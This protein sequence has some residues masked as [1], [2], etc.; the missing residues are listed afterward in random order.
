MQNTLKKNKKMLKS[1]NVSKKEFDKDFIQK[2]YDA[3]EFKANNEM[4]KELEE[5]LRSVWDDNEFVTGVISCVCAV[6]Q[7]EM[8]K[9]LI[10]SKGKKTH[11]KVTLVK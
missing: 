8:I 1:F 2:V 10:V 9:D 5:L 6:N 3:L 4:V 11:I 7:E